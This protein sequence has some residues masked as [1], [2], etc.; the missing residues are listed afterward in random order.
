MDRFK[1]I[2]DYIQEILGVDPDMIELDTNLVDDLNADSLDLVEMA[3]TLEDHYEI[4][5][6]DEELESVQTVEDVLNLLEDHLDD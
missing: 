4:E 2:K 5:F 3:M 6:S 1:E